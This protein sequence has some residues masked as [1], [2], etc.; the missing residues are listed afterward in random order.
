MP[1]CEACKPISRVVTR[2]AAGPITK[3]FVTLSEDVDTVCIPDDVAA[4]LG[5]GVFGYGGA[6]ASRPERFEDWLCGEM[7]RVLPPV[8]LVLPMHSPR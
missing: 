5:Y 3:D 4:L 8:S 2:T 1:L 6:G 7:G